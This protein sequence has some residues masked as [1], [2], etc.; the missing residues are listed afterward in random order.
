[1]SSQ[2]KVVRMMGDR[3]KFK[4]HPIIMLKGTSG[5]I[6]FLALI[7]FDNIKKY[8]DL[9]TGT[10]DD[11][12]TM[13]WSSLFI[14]GICFLT[15]IV[16]FF[17]WRNISIYLDEE[18]I[19][20][21]YNGVFRRS[22]KQVSIKNVSSVNVITGIWSRIWGAREIQLDINSSETAE[23]S[24][25]KL[26]LSVAQAEAFK[27]MIE[28]AKDKGRLEQESIEISAQAETAQPSDDEL[29]VKYAFT[30]RQCIEN[31]VIRFSFIELIMFVGFMAFGYLSG[32]E[33][34]QTMIVA[35]A[36]WVVMAIKN[37]IQYM[38]FKVERQR[39][40]IHLSYGWL[41]TQSY[42]I[43]VK[44]I[45]SIGMNQGFV[46]KLLGYEQVVVNTIGIGNESGE[47][48]DLSIYLKK[49]DI[50]AFAEE[51]IPEIPLVDDF[52]GQPCKTW[53]YKS[54]IN[55]VILEMICVGLSYS[56]GYR[57]IL[58]IGVPVGMIL[59]YIHY[60]SYGVQLTSNYIAVKSGY[61]ST[62]TQT[63]Y[64]SRIDQ[65]IVKQNIL[66]KAMGIEKMRFK[67]R[68]KSG[69]EENGTGYYKKGTF[70]YILEDFVND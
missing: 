22:K 70:D 42:M 52:I 44:N 43:P 13:L 28:E 61:F 45:I 32:E 58:L 11:I 3:V 4:N 23:H 33:S 7:E 8:K 29:S 49:A 56:L 31:A 16:Q 47:L 55:S 6:V 60:K 14:I 41:R 46:A 50:R 54:V 63:L 26:I 36:I 1:M 15:I 25:Y 40:T 18:N 10:K 35:I 39:D 34:I 38:N 37:I 57:W 17:K 20:Y 24:D 59:A 66:C 62:Q 65:V 30:A 5:V 12:N 68:G 9:L 48:S 53:I 19:Y 51:V 27:K 2:Q 21:E 69:K 64:F 67:S